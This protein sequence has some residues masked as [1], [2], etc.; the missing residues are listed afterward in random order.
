[1]ARAQS[2]KA[3]MRFCKRYPWRARAVYALLVLVALAWCA[4]ASMHGA[5]QQVVRPM[6]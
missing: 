3:L 6:V 5:G 1:M 4:I 2:D